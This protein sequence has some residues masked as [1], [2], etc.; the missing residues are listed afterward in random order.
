ML[1]HERHELGRITSDVEKLEIIL[2]DKLVKVGMSG[3][4]HPMAVRV[5]QRLAQRDEWLD[6]ASRSHNLNNNI[7]RWRWRLTRAATET[8]WN[9]CLRQ[10]LLRLYCRN[11]ILQDGR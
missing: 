10:W 4:S 11:L 3:D 1:D 9:V 7:Q 5:F 6:I 8:W 2:F